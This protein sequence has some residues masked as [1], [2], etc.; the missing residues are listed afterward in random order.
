MLAEKKKKEQSPSD[1]SKLELYT[2]LGEGY[3][4]MKEGRE[5]S[6]DAVKQRLEE[7]RKKY[8]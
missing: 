8:E 5:S 4:A 2:L 7:R 6:V 1:E 3:K